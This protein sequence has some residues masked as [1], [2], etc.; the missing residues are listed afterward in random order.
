M[1]V[2]RDEGALTEIG[3]KLTEVRRRIFSVSK[4]R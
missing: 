1:E 3:G 4:R 2:G